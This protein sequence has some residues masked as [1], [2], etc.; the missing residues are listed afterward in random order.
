M[1]NS[2]YNYNTF[3][4]DQIE[5]IVEE[6]IYKVSAVDYTINSNKVEFKTITG[7]ST[8]TNLDGKKIINLS[9]Q[10]QYFFTVTTTNRLDIIE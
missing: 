4:N 6:T 3:K 5:D 2:N 10:I 8:G 9:N 1:E 7:E